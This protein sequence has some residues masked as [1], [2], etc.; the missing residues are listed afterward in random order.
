MSEGRDPTEPLAR[1]GGEERISIVVT[2]AANPIGSFYFWN[3]TRRL[4]PERLVADV[5]AR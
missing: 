4:S 1:R 5:P 2:E 3:R